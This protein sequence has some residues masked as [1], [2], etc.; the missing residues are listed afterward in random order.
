MTQKVWKYT[1]FSFGA[2]I[3]PKIRQISPVTKIQWHGKDR[4]AL[5]LCTVIHATLTIFCSLFFVLFFSTDQLQI[6]VGQVCRCVLHFWHAI[7]RVRDV[8]INDDQLSQVR[9]TADAIRSRLLEDATKL[10][11]QHSVHS[12]SAQ[13]SHESGVDIVDDPGLP[14]LSTCEVSHATAENSMAVAS[15]CQW[16]SGRP[17]RFTGVSTGR[18]TR[19]TDLGNIVFLKLLSVKG[20]V[21]VKYSH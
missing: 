21:Y 12:L 4:E 3:P 13:S 16:Y 5:C 9:S 18:C 15:S 17:G 19:S 2:P 8:N 14:P 10:S 11:E 20:N 7:A 1:Y 6:T